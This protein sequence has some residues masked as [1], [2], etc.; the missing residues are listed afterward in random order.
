MYEIKPCQNDPYS[1]LI[2]NSLAQEFPS[3]CVADSAVLVD[4]ITSEIM[5]TKQQRRGPRPSPESLVAMRDVIR[6]N[7]EM[8]WPIPFVVPW[9]SEKPDGGGID[10]AELWALKTL[11]CLNHRVMGHYSPGLE[12]HIRVE[13]VSAP[14]LFY[15][16][17]DQAREEAARYSD[18]FEAVVA[19]LELGPAIE[20][21]RESRHISE[22][23]FNAEADMIVPA[24][25]AVL[26]NPENTNAKT[27][28]AGFGWRGIPS[29]ELKQFYFRQFDKLYPN[30]DP[31]QRLHRLARYFSASLARKRLDLTG[32]SPAWEGK[33]VE[34]AFYASPPGTQTH[35]ARR[36][37]YRTLPCAITSNHMAPW[38]SKGYMLIED[39]DDATPKLAS[40]NEPQ[41]Y[42][43]NTV[44]LVNDALVHGPRSVTVQADYIVA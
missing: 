36:V 7:T 39:D 11:Q 14:H 20:I 38:R 40:F 33:F 23:K 42:N 16:R 31:G 34:L 44:T 41:N 27:D 3:Q 1:R 37:Y 15:D 22:E 9:G 13:D 26:M 17:M 2:A 21:V 8:K 30:D 6:R 29:E 12:F 10:L 18:A 43:K 28:L 25:Q 32:A 5:G 4:L 19:I 24:M 35:F